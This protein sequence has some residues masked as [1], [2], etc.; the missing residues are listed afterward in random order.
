LEEGI[1]ITDPA[2]YA[3]EERCPDTVIAHVFRPAP[4]CSE[5]I[6]LLR[7]RIDIMREVGAILVKEY[8]GSFLGF[9]HKFHADRGTTLLQF[10]L[11]VVR[12]FPSFRDETSYGGLRL[13]FWK[14]AQIL[15]A[16]AWAAFY[17]LHG[18]HPLFPGGGAARI[19]MFADYRVPQILHHL[20]LLDYPPALAALL[21]AHAP[22]EHGSREEVS[23][24]A[25]SIVA[26]ERIADEIRMRRSTDDGPANENAGYREVCSVLIDFY[27]WDLAKC[28]EHG[29]KVVTGIR[30]SK[31]LPAHRTRSIWY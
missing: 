1:Q 6:P 23:I 18:A 28:I 15:A 4:G 7:E 30:T 27:L 19:T 29:T 13:Y 17:P 22:L 10:V 3:S 5:T 26:V 9:V 16:E 14:R 20:G 24:R 21:E 2:F 11:K 8:G 12:T 25:A 31:V